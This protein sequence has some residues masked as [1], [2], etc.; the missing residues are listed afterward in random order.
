MTVVRQYDSNTST[1]VE[2]LGAQGAQGYQGAQG[3]TGSQGDWSAAQPN[4]TWSSSTTLT[5]SDAGKL[6]LVDSATTISVTTSLALS[7]GQRIDFLITSSTVPTISAAS[8][9]TLNGTPTT[10][11]RTQ[12]SAA[13]LICVASNS[14]VL[15][16]DLAAV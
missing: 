1:W 12:Y 6:I 3:S 4:R 10:K 7:V 8:G 11:F 5:S 13:T 9:A 15:V 2:I 16:G 14:Y